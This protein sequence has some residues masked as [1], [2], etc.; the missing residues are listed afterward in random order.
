VI[1]TETH[2]QLPGSYKLIWWQHQ[3]GHPTTHSEG[4]K[5]GLR[6]KRTTVHQEILQSSGQQI[7]NVQL[8][9]EKGNQTPD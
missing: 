9:A 8:I 4:G 7:L 3:P 1:I 2:A 5:P 6:A